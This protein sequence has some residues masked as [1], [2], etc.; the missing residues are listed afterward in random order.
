[1]VTKGTVI[2][3]SRNYKCNVAW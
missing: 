2:K 3:R 1:M